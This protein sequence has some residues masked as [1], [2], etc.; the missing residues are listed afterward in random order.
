MPIAFIERDEAEG[1]LDARQRDCGGDDGRTDSGDALLADGTPGSGVNKATLNAPATYKTNGMFT[2]SDQVADLLGWASPTASLTVKVDT[3]AP[4]LSLSCS[5]SRRGSKVSAGFSA[6]DAESG[7]STAA[8]G[9]FTQDTS[10]YGYQTVTVTARD[11][12]GHVTTKSC[13][14]RVY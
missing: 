7:L 12:V 8:T 2:A 6:K 4:T 10:R 13:T 14:Y 5:D 9:S 11:K 1:T 3:T